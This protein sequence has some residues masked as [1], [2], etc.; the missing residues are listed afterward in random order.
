[1]KT[2]RLPIYLTP[3]QKEKLNT[4]STADGRSMNSY[5]GRLIE[6]EFD[7]LHPQEKAS[8][9]MEQKLTADTTLYTFTAEF[10]GYT[11]FDTIL[12]P[13]SPSEYAE[14]SAGKSEEENLRELCDWMESTFRTGSYWEGVWPNKADANIWLEEQERTP[15]AHTLESFTPRSIHRDI[16]EEG[17]REA[18]KLAEE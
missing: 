5:V 7:R 4:L 13:Q 2:E 17:K 16:L 15:T 6:R 8:K 18:E 1:M 10:D 11:L 14:R 12:G 9:K 3:E